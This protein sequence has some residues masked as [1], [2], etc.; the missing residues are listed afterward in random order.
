MKC[1]WLVNWLKKV[2][3]EFCVDINMVQQC[4]KCLLHKFYYIQTFCI[5][6]KKV[7]VNKI[8][9]KVDWIVFKTEKIS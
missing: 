7:K 1:E 6:A 2:N 9:Q 8:I 4:L 5:L 3:M